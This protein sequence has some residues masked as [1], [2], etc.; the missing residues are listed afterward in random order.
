MAG[1]A[2]DWVTRLAKRM[3]QKQVEDSART[4]KAQSM[5]MTQADAG[6]RMLG[7][8]LKG[9]H[10][11]TSPTSLGL[12]AGTVVAPEVFGPI[13]IGMGLHGMAESGAIDWNDFTNL[14]NF[15]DPDKLQD[16][17][18][19]ASQV[20]GG[21]A[22]TGEGLKAVGA[23]SAAKQSAPDVQM[24]NFM[25]A[26]PPS[27]RANY[28]PA[29]YYVA[30][31]YLEA[32]IPAGS[33]VEPK[34][35]RMAADTQIERFESNI[36]SAIAMDPTRVIGGD[37]LGDVALELK[38]RSSKAGF[39]EAGMKYL[40]DTWPQLADPL[41]IEEADKIRHDMNQENKSVLNA[42][43]SNETL[44]AKIYTAEQTDPAF[45]ARQAG[46][47][48]LRT[49]VY[50]TLRDMGY[51]DA[52]RNR[53]IEGSLIKIRNAAARQELAGEQAV[54]GTKPA[55]M[56]RKAAARVLPRVGGATGA[57]LG[58]MGAKAAGLP[59]E[60]G[61]TAGFIAGEGAGAI[62]AEALRG[63]PKTKSDLL[64]SSFNPT[65][66]PQNRT[67]G[68]ARRFFFTASDGNVHSVPDTPE[69][70]QA[71]LQADPNIKPLE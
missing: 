67:V 57:G 54:K 30:R 15:K 47:E 58:Y 50:D 32:E 25:K 63:E 33:A 27:A 46:L 42:I 9:V 43:P 24:Q 4:G 10:E 45:A 40:T 5:L 55:G 18:N 11:A 53:S 19:A 38:T 23:R 65:A 51:A 70:R 66:Q 8:T 34:T 13:V 1:V 35:V 7:D 14:E 31:P 16:F 26:I 12:A 44:G 48:A 22:M 6:V 29:N 52:E 2:G 49:R 21:A 60:A 69:H 61:A 37:P 17:L 28:G 3:E 39:L 36:K 71:V 41:T 20:A 59:P 62:G 64:T 68:G 56:V